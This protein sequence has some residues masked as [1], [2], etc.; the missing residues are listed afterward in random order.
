LTGGQQIQKAED[1]ENS[2]VSCLFSSASHRI[3]LLRVAS[4]C[5]DG[6][7]LLFLTNPFCTRRYHCQAAI[8]PVREP[9][10]CTAVR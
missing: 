2:N 7:L 9:D 10:F 5:P 3:F 1:S 6:S 8:N 4:N